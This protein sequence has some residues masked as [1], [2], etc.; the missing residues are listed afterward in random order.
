MFST[1]FKALF[2]SYCFLFFSV[3]LTGFVTSNSFG[4]PAI[5]KPATLYDFY[6]EHCTD[7][8]EKKLIEK[9]QKIDEL[10][11]ELNKKASKSSIAAGATDP[12]INTKLLDQWLGRAQRE[13][14]SYKAV[15][16][17]TPVR[18]H[19]LH[20]GTG[21]NSVDPLSTINGKTITMLPTSSVTSHNGTF[22]FSRAPLTQAPATM[23]YPDFFGGSNPVGS[24]A[25]PGTSALDLVAAVGKC[26]G[27]FVG[28]HYQL[29]PAFKY[30]T[31]GK[32]VPVEVF[33]F[34]TYEGEP[35]V[36]VKTVSG[37]ITIIPE[38]GRVV[39]DP[40]IGLAN[41]TDLGPHTSTNVRIPV[42]EAYRFENKS[43][44]NFVKD[45]LSKVQNGTRT[46]FGITGSGPSAIWQGGLLDAF[47]GPDFDPKQRSLVTIEL[48]VTSSEANIEKVLEQMKKF[49]EKNKGIYLHED[50]FKLTK[51][52]TGK[53]L[54][55]ING[56][57]V[58]IHEVQRNTASVT[59]VDGKLEY[60]YTPK[61]GGNAVSV[62]L[63]SPFLL[64][65]QGQKIPD[66]FA[67]TLL[68]CT[69][70]KAKT[71]KY[72]TVGAV[73]THLSGIVI[74]LP[75]HMTYRLGEMVSEILK[76]QENGLNPE[77]IKQ[78][79]KFAEIAK[80]T[81]GTLNKIAIHQSGLPLL[82][83]VQTNQTALSPPTQEVSHPIP[84]NEAE[85]NKISKNPET[86][87]SPSTV[88]TEPLNP[89]ENLQSRPPLL[90]KAETNSI[91]ARINALKKLPIGGVSSGLGLPAA[92]VIGGRLIGE[93]F[94]DKE[95]GDNASLT[96]GLIIGIATAGF[97]ATAGGGALG[98]AGH[99][100]ADKLEKR[101]K[102]KYGDETGK[103]VGIGARML[104][105]GVIGLTYGGAPG[106]VVGTAAGGVVELSEAA[107]EYREAVKEGYKLKS[108]DPKDQCY[109]IILNFGGAKG[110]FNPLSK[111]I[112]KYKYLN[113]SQKRDDEMQALYLDCVL[114]ASDWGQGSGPN[115]VEGR[116]NF[117]SW[118]KN[119]FVKKPVVQKR[120]ADIYNSIFNS[121]LSGEELD[122]WTKCVLSN[123]L[124][125]TIQYWI[126]LQ[127]GFAL[128]IG[129][130]PQ[131]SDVAAWAKTVATAVGNL[132]TRN[133]NITEG[134]WNSPEAKSNRSKI[135]TELVKV[136]N[137][138]SRKPLTTNEI[139][140][141][142]KEIETQKLPLTHLGMALPYSN[143]VAFFNRW[144][145]LVGR[146]PTREELEE[147]LKNYYWEH[148]ICSNDARKQ[149]IKKVFLLTV[150]REP[151]EYNLERLLCG[152]QPSYSK[153]I[154]ELFEQ[155]ATSEEAQAAR[156]FLLMNGSLT[157]FSPYDSRF[158][159]DKPYLQF[160]DPWE[161]DFPPYYR[162]WRTGDPDKLV[163]RTHNR[164]SKDLWKRI[165]LTKLRQ[166]YCVILKR[167]ATDLE[168]VD[169]WYKLHLG[170]ETTMGP[171]FDEVAFAILTSD[172]AAK[173]SP[174]APAVVCKDPEKPAEPKMNQPNF[175][176]LPQPIPFTWEVPKLG[177]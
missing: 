165:F 159:N 129:R 146:Y 27:G 172:E 30:G 22:D 16:S 3:L 6:L 61:A 68:E 31:D 4:G 47:S 37:W 48:F 113:S 18:V 147:G 89:F 169:F 154:N 175:F 24:S 102:K 99:I 114:G 96:G 107:W 14:N 53:A 25:A 144:V 87:P 35:A 171:S 142:E 46:S 92:I 150:G 140:E 161:G 51:D 72:G 80:E 71:N 83:A 1:L 108:D 117:Y 40:G 85:I 69:D 97:R 118:W 149:V 79:S 139:A 173:V 103:N 151:D 134:V 116:G 9:M 132:E 133:I 170:S 174:T 86:R 49:A 121:A 128:F 123:T 84:T 74:E 148:F 26:Y 67:R 43:R 20:I 131:A 55:Q 42:D 137:L 36:K 60:R 152:K 41:L 122:Q 110:A 168:I 127:N 17:E 82:D 125:E 88:N 112:D 66:H 7:P 141:F 10:I 65:A 11:Q 136:H 160:G 34:T 32:M 12:L 104:N 91:V 111:N 138:K 62:T 124:L 15:K 13:Y 130:P 90:S 73:G 77:Q 98:W 100:V 163:S 115:E 57:T 157:Y 95:L 155:L 70:W 52:S 39:L 126:D 63:N 166:L 120:I 76:T 153:P 5:K 109:K 21:P 156:E 33:E 56:M 135:L 75:P 167:N 93:I 19:S 143:D 8:D 176:S 45:V 38:G 54:L 2:N 119:Y 177:E 50:G 78:A 23:S 59:S 58:N 29:E 101:T 81:K 164:R 162:M 94:D 64:E 158:P 28:A 105:F 106:A 145:E 44:D